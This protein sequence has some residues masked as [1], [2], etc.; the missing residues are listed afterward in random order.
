VT[1]ARENSLHDGKRRNKTPRLREQNDSKR[2]DGLFVSLP[3]YEGGLEFHSIL[4][5]S[6]PKWRFA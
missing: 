4:K 5:T 3:T 1:R 2:R 6:Y